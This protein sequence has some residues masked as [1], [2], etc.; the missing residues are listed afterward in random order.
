MFILAERGSS[1]FFILLRNWR[2]AIVNSQYVKS[3]L[4]VLLISA[5]LISY[6]IVSNEPAIPAESSVK[7][8]QTQPDTQPIA[9]SPLA[10]PPAPTPVQ[11]SPQS[12]EN[13]TS[14]PSAPDCTPAPRTALSSIDIANAGYGLTEIIEPPKTYRVY[15]YSPAQ[16]REQIRRCSPVTSHNKKYSAETSY[17]VNWRYNSRKTADGLCKTTDA[18]VAIRMQITYPSWQPSAYD[19]SG[20]Q[21][22]WTRFIKAL[23]VHEQEHLRL[24]REYARNLLRTIED[25]PAT[26]CSELSGK[27]RGDIDRLIAAVKNQHTNYDSASNHG[28]TQGAIW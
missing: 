9:D 7:G 3:W 28:A 2:R 27:L 4:F 25:F 24:N 1:S 23:E 19:Q 15:G 18:K 5:G 26:G 8:L 21:S 22:K 6:G 12:Q 13:S 17:K 16:I 14:L 20:L 11:S 10:T